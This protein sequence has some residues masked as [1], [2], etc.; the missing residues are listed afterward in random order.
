MC[1]LLIINLAIEKL[2]AITKHTVGLEILIH[3][4]GAEFSSSP[5]MEITLGDPFASF[6]LFNSFRFHL[7]HNPNFQSQKF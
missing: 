6:N 7:I 5:P 4:N 1:V 3:N 2:K